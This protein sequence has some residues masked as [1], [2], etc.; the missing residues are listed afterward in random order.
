VSESVERAQP[1]VTS[2]LGVGWIRDMSIRRVE[3]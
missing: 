3:G 2:S 1:M